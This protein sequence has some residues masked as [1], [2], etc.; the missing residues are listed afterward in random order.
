MSNERLPPRGLTGLIKTARHYFGTQLGNTANAARLRKKYGLDTLP[1]Q[2]DE[3]RE[4]YAVAVVAIFKGEDEYLREWLEF[5]RIVG[6]EHF[7]LYDNGD[8]QTSREILKPYIDDGLVTYLPF[9]DFP[10]KSMR[11]RY[12]K[13]QFRKLSMQ[14]LAYGD[15]VLRYAEHCKWL[16]K[17]D[18]DEFLYPLEPFACLSDAFAA[19]DSS[20]VK[21]FSVRAKRFG[22]SGR[23][24]RSGLPVIETFTM[25]NP[26]PDRNWKVVGK[27]RYLNGKAC[28]QGCHTYFYKPS[29]RARAFSDELTERSVMINHYYIKSR[30]EYLDKIERHSVGHKAGKESPEKWQ[31]ADADARTKDEG[32]ILRF[33][34]LL[35]ERLA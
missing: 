10:E 33:L 5:H 4:K 13:D 22:P 28:Y 7:F 12:G 2:E 35:K 15:C 11:N 26:E 25:R 9:V 8:S 1:F 18:L 20:Q 23:I 16:A 19:L 34:P 3:V 31:L 17:I 30:A 24:E 21:G 29:L 27:G 32:E 14:N 6:V